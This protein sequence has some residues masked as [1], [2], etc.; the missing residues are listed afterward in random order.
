MTMISLAGWW[1]WL[2]L[3][4][5]LAIASLWLALAVVTF[6]LALATLV[7]Q[8]ATGRSGLSQSRTTLYIGRVAHTRF[9]PKVHSFAYPFFWMGV[10]LK[11]VDEEFNRQWWPLSWIMSF[12]SRH[13]Y[14]N[15]EG[16]LPKDSDRKDNELQNSSLKERTFR[17]V[18]E[19]TQHKLVPTSATHSV[20]LLTHLSYLGYCFNPVSFYYVVDC[21]TQKLEAIVAEVSNTPWNE[22]FSY[23]L[24]PH[25]VDMTSVSDAKEGIN[26]VFAKNFHVSPFMEMDYMYDWTFSELSSLVNSDSSPLVITTAMI[27]K[28]PAKTC[29]FRARVELRPT[30]PDPLKWA[31]Q[32]IKFPAYCILVQLWIHYEAF[33]LFMKGIVFQP[34]PKG[35]ETTA[36]LIIGTLMAPLFAL[37][38]WM[39]GGGETENPT[40][41]K[42][43]S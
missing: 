10:D 17:L 4:A 5:I 24:H 43:K 21:K 35:S 14:K 37:K 13:H 30:S 41:E 32:L 8:S 16:L 23:V 3:Y 18:A 2:F 11:E 29:Q 15:G 9:H 7:R 19:R 12:Q 1:T 38:D 28:D 22:M 39:E 31:W 20:I 33:W 6:S 40:E 27:Q 42:K 25:S 26:Y 36:S 34:H